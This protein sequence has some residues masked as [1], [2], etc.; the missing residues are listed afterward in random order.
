MQSA[1]NFLFNKSLFT[2]IHLS[3]RH[4]SYSVLR[5]C[6]GEPAASAPVNSSGARG[7]NGPGVC[8]VI[9]LLDRQVYWEHRPGKENLRKTKNQK[10]L[11]NV[12]LQD[13]CFGCPRKKKVR[14]RRQLSLLYSKGTPGPQEMLDEVSDEGMNVRSSKRLKS[15]GRRTEAALFP[16]PPGPANSTPPPRL[17]LNLSS[18]QSRLPD[19]SRHRKSYGTVPKFPRTPH[20]QS[21]CPGYTVM[22]AEFNATSPEPGAE[23]DGAR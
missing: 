10:H 15:S 23:P 9:K 5:Q 14:P 8:G 13:V 17:T 11:H 21:R 22:S 19:P 4:Q 12:H 20:C 2:Y 1:G 3:L 6:T 7:P 18:S 16:T